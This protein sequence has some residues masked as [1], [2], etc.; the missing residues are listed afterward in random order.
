MGVLYDIDSSSSRTNEILN[1]PFVSAECRQNG[2]A[3]TPRW[4]PRLED[5]GITTP[6]ANK[7]DQDKRG[8]GVKLL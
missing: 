8:A 3:E 6:S 5:P 7:S 1:M 2:V 4:D